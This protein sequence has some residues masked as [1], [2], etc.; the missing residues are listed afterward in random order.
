MKTRRGAYYSCHAATTAPGEG[1]ESVHRRK[2]RRTVAEGSPAAAGTPGVRLAGDMFEELPDDLVVSILRDVAASA[3]SLAD[4]AGA[5]LTYV[6][7]VPY[8][9]VHTVCCPV[10]LREPRRQSVDDW[11]SNL[12]VMCLRT[13]AGARDSGS[14]GRPSWCSRG[15]RRGASRCAPRPGRT[16]RT[17]SCSAAPTPATSKLAT[18]LAW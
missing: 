15:R 16:T 13:C 6:L 5:M 3:G 1:P 9:I 7:L 18:F 14:S 8:S 10:R 4:L 2:R 11:S 17:G 12:D